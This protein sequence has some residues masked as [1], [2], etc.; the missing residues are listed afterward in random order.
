MAEPARP[1]SVSAPTLL[2]WGELP[3]DVPGEWVDGALED[4][5]MAGWAHEVVVAWLLATLHAWAKGALARVVGS[6]A[7]LAVSGSRGRKADLI[8]YLRGAPRPSGQGLVRVPPSIVVEVV[9]P[10]PSDARRDRIHKLDDYAAFGVR[11]YWLVDPQLRTLEI[12]E[13]GA[14]GRYVRALGASE[15]M[16]AAVPG[17]DGLALDLD[18]MW[19]D[20]AAA[21]AE[22][23]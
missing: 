2:A 16:I 17:C 19:A 3:E 10:S 9:S 22:G 6:D 1:L 13:L 8:V 23:E 20:L 14:D 5:E 7:K 12:L 4:D 18:A 21:L 15:G 11:W